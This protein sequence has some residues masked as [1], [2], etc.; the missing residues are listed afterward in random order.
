MDSPVAREPAERSRN[1][2]VGSDLPNP[3]LSLQIKEA[4]QRL[5]FDLVGISPVR[6]PPHAPSFAEWLRAGFH[7]DMGYMARTEW[8]RRDPH[9]LLPWAVSVVS[10]AMN[11]YTPLA[12]PKQ[13]PGATGW[14]SRYAWGDDYHTLVRARLEALLEKV[15]ELC[16]A[17]VEGRVFVDSGPVLERDFAGT[18]GIGWLGKNT[19]LISPAK[20]SWFFLGELFLSIPLAYDRPIRNRCGACDLCLRACPTGAFVGPYVLDARRCISYLTIELKGWIPR[21]LRPLIGNHIFGC[22]ICQ[23]VCPYNVK[24]TPTREAAFAP[25]SGLHAPALIPL[26]ALSEEEFRA[27]FR[28]SP[29]LRAKRRG[30]LRNVAVALGNLRSIEA[31]PA[32]LHALGDDEPLVRG[33]AAWALGRIGSAAARSGLQCR[34]EAETDP[35]VKDEIEAALAEPAA[36]AS[37]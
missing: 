5:G 36:S 31:V 3:G 9:E 37:A 8:P 20:G 1:E 30:F 15:R 34:L 24:A 10:A 4:G 11:Y 22:D 7:G 32:L 14:I 25:R 33:H 6:P 28:D 12:R 27:R 17:P 19:H 26:L 18:A 29:I 2:A 21:H 35:Q 16:G 23:E 13:A